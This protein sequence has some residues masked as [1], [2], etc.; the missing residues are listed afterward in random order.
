[1]SDEPMVSH[2]VTV[3]DLLTVRRRVYG[4]APN[5]AAD[6]LVLGGTQTLTLDVGNRIYCLT[7]FVN[8]I[9]NWCSRLSNAIADLGLNVVAGNAVVVNQVLAANHAHLDGRVLNGVQLLRIGI[10]SSGTIRFT[11]SAVFWDNF[12]IT[13]NDYAL[14][15]LGLTYSDM[16]YT[17]YGNNDQYNSN[18]SQYL[19]AGAVIDTPAASLYALGNT[20]TYAIQGNYTLLRFLEERLYVALEVD[21]S[22]PWNATIRNGKQVATHQIATYPIKTELLSTIS[23]SNTQV[24]TDVTIQTNSNVGRVHFTQKTDPAAQWYTLQSSYSIQNTRVMVYIMR[25]R[26]DSTDQIWKF[27]RKPMNIHKDAVWNASLK[28]VSVF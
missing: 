26:Y 18:D 14:Q 21:L 6:A 3:Q 7:D 15:L 1:M 28:F 17:R 25:R 4:A 16:C 11:G 13:S 20:R 23:S 19:L 27:E 10:T 2:D 8:L 22:L 24:T 5:T 12:Y 9:A